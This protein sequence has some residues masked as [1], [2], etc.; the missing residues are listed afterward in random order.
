MPSSFP[1]TLEGLC[2]LTS[3]L[4]ALLLLASD[5]RALGAT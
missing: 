2:F 3:T 1:P 4:F 5:A